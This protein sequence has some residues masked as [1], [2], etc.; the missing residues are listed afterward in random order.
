MRCY[1]SFYIRNYVA[2]CPQIVTT[3]FY[4]SKTM[5]IVASKQY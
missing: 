2:N 1:G 3:Q 4:I 5:R